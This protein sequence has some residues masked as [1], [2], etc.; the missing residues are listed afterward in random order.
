MI[1]SWI[2]SLPSSDGTH[3]G[4]SGTIALRGALEM[5]NCRVSGAFSGGGGLACDG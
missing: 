3:T 4:T 2:R 1:W 5:V